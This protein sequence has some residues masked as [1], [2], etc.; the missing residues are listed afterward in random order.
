MCSKDNSIYQRVLSLTPT[1][2][3]LHLGDFEESCHAQRKFE[4]TFEEP[5]MTRVEFRGED[6]LIEYLSE[7]VN[8]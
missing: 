7:G 5:Y 1:L 8:R 6:G 2:I 3:L 4:K